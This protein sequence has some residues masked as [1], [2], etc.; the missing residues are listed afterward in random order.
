M[1]NHQKNSGFTLIELLVTIVIASILIAAIFVLIKSYRQMSSQIKSDIDTEFYVT[2]FI[3]SFSEDIASSGYQAIDTTLTSIYNAGKVINF[4]YGTSPNVNSVGITTDLTATTRQTVT[5][6]IKA[7]NP[8]RSKSYANELGIYKSKSLFNTNSTSI[9]V[10]QD[11]LML[12]GVKSFQCTESFNPSPV[13]VNAATR[14]VSCT[15]IMN[16][17][18]NLTTPLTKTYNFYAKAENQF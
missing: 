9:A 11:A 1:K 3:D 12:A 13:N 14:G 17:Y 4:I 18:L 15:L 7:M 10:Y 2:E 16:A 8:A 5:Y 6:T